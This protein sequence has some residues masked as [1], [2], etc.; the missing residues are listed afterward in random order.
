M[1]L[2]YLLMALKIIIHYCC[3]SYDQGV[4]GGVARYDYHIKLA[5][6]QRILSFSK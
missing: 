5:F 4:H 2:C 3:G 1:D 6:P